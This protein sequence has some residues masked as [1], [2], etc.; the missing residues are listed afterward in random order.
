MNRSEIKSLAK[1]QIK[2]KIGIL[3]VISLLYSLIRGTALSHRLISL[4]SFSGMPTY[5]VPRYCV[6]DFPKYLQR[7]SR[8]WEPKLL[9]GRLRKITLAEQV[10]I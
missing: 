4:C 8:K 9:H 2:G 5:Q 6:K 7:A 1:Q 3:F 10:R